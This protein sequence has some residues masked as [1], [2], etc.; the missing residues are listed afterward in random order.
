MKNSIFYPENVAI[1]GASPGYFSGGSSFLQSLIASEFPKD[2]IFPINPKYEEINGIKAYPSLLDVPEN[3]D[4]CIIAVPKESAFQ[5]LKDCAEKGV[6]LVCSFTSGFSEIGEKEDEARFISIAKNGNVRLLG[7]NCIGLC[8]P[9]IRL[10]FNQGIK[11]GEEWSGNVSIISQSG[12]NADALMITGNGIGLKFNTCVSYGNGADINAD[13]LL[14]YFKDDPETEL[15]IQYLEGF[16]TLEQ[17]RNY[18][19]ILRETTPIKP[20]IIWQGGMTKVGKRSILSHTGSISGD[21]K[22]I[23]SAFKQTGAI[24]VDYGG[25]DLLYTALLISNL[26]STNKLMDI[27]PNIGS[28]L[29]GGG[30]NVYFADLCSRYGLKF[31][32]F[33]QDTLL[34][35][36][37]S[38]GEIGTLLRNPIDLNVKMFDMKYV[39]KVMKILNELSYIDIITFEPGLDWG[40]MNLQL[41]Q[42]INPNGNIDFAS[43]LE[44]N[45]KTLIR[46]IKKIKKPVVVI[47]SQTFC[48]AEIVAKRN[49]MEDKFR[50]QNI[51]VFDSIETMAKAILNSIEYKK[52]LNKIN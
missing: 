24:L 47:S 39:V 15:I 20:V 36:K 23:K 43:M 19:K 10:S 27:G 17:G 38:I 16:K 5:A 6:K 34:E 13:E 3:I 31:P 28:I 2:K 42:K 40:I 35:L 26:K 33:D 51:P 41:M 22:I 14:Q 7:P 48:D 45:S 30:N 8:V 37:E 49:Q 44:S 25:T 46:N 18:L 12:G 9:K 29:G 11:A 21:N 32:D 1:I 52:F 50:K 4:Y